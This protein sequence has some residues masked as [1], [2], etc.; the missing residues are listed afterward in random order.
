[1]IKKDNILKRKIKR[2]FRNRKNISGT[3]EKP[4]LTVFRSLNHMYAQLIDDSCGKTLASASTKSKELLDDIK[5]VKGK[6]EKA[7]LVGKLIAKKALEANLS[8]VV[9][10][11]GSYIYHGRVKAL[12][13]GARE[14]GLKF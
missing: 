9:F 11:R 2:A 4:R 14:G 12:A 8:S 7:K 1:M 3:T 5:N 13:E 10:D 6:I